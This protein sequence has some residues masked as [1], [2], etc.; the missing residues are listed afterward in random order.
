MAAHR[1]DVVALSFS[2]VLAN[3]AVHEGLS[4]LRTLLPAAVE[5][6]AGAATAR[7]PRRAGPAGVR[8]LPGLVQISGEV[9]RWRAPTPD[10]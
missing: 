5:V 1:A 2:A 10:A 6:W 3:R 9:G 8:V 4:R 7:W